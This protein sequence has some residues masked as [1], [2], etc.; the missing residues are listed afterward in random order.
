MHRKKTAHVPVV[1]QMEA[2]ECGAASLAMICAYYDKWLPLERVRVDCGVSRDGASAKNVLQAARSYGLKAEGYRFERAEDLKQKGIFPCIIH[3][4]FYHF[5][6]LCGF[7]GNYAIINDPA[8]GTV[9]I[10]LKEFDES[11]TGVCLFF[12]PTDSFTPSGKRKS[13]ASYVREYLTGSYGPVLFLLLISFLALFLGLLQPAFERFFVD[14]LLTGE[15]RELLM[16]F[17][18]LLTGVVLLQLICAVIR[19]ISL[20]RLKGKIALT[21]HS[22]FFWKLLHMPMEFFGA[23]SAADLLLRQ[24]ANTYVAEVVTETYLPLLV[25]TG[26]TIVY[27]IVMLRYSLILTLA[28]LAGLFFVLLSSALINWKR[29]DLMRVMMRDLGKQNSTAVSGIQMIES[30]KAGGA[31]SAFF[32][33]WA[34]LQASANAKAVKLEGLE[35]TMGFLPQL[36][37]L[38]AEAFVLVF[39]VWLVMDQKFTLGS[40]ALFQGVLTLLLSPALKTASAGEKIQRMRSDMERLWDV[41]NYSVKSEE[42]KEREEPEDMEYEKLTGALQMEHVSFGYSRLAPP[43]IEDFSLTVKQG[44]RIALVGE[45]GCGKSTL[46]RLITGLYRP[47]SGSILFDGKPEEEIPRSIF[48]A[49]VAV[50]DQEITLFQDSVASNIKMWDNSIEDFEMIL[51]AEDAKI[52][53]DIMQRDGGFQSRLLTGGK[54]L[55]GGQR[56]RLEIARVLAQDPTLLIMD[57]ATSALDAKTEYELVEAVKQRGITCIVIAHRLSTIRDCDEILV[58]DHGRVAERGTHEELYAKGGLYAEL[59]SSD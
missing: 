47:W 28:G 8:R 5:V 20:Y 10:P 26:M 11:F 13:T 42:Q 44:Q 14:R 4:N 45:S 16:P 35:L 58:L 22:S 3:W 39:G 49:S 54:D 51:A 19:T 41:S 59:V 18:L 6:V 9:R 32:R 57:E 12:A 37:A 46:A 21:G 17:V 38:L 34:G 25:N 24:E 55:S 2:Q 36:A 29:R 31:E 33:R 52:R 48:T 27:V 23:R 40:I 53:E 50:V 43:L 7:R 15:N 1:L 30:I 56:Q